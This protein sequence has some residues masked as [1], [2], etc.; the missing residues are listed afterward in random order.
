MTEY[1][2]AETYLSHYADDPTITDEVRA[3][4]AVMLPKVNVVLDAYV[5]D[6]GILDHNEFTE[7]PMAGTGNGGVRPPACKVGAADSPHKKGRGVDVQDIYRRLAVWLIA[8]HEI[9]LDQ[10]LHLEDFRWTPTWVHFQDYPPKS[11]RLLYI[12]SRD[13]P[14]AAALRGQ[15]ELERIIV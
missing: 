15:E 7:S 12:P 4:A 3:A 9:L 8:N 14:M 10:G 2:S 1:I 11:G 13:A 6:G 5:S